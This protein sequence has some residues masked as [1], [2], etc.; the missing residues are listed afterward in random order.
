MTTIYERPSLV[1]L[2]NR[3]AS[4]LS[5]MPDILRGPLTKSLAA[6]AH[7]EHGHLD[8]IQRQGSPLTCEL[9]MLYQWASLYDVP[10]LIAMPAEG[11]VKVTGNPGTDLLIDTLARGQNGFD[12]R[13]VMGVTINNDGTASAHVRCEDAGENTN[14]LAGQT[15]T[16]IDPVA[17][18]DDALTVDENGLT[19]GANEE[20]LD[21]WRLRV[22]DEWQ[23]A[24]QVGARG[25]RDDDYRYWAKSAH[26]SVTTALVYKHK[27]GIGTVIVM[28]ICNPLADRL[29]TLSILQTVEDYIRSKAPVGGDDLY[30]VAPA[31]QPVTVQIEL[32]NASDTQSNR[33][34]IIASLSVL[35]NSK[36]A[37][38]DFILLSEIDDAISSVTRQYIRHEPNDTVTAGYGCVMTLSV[39][40]L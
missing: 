33:N 6:V 32:L 27:L 17:G 28:P 23:T 5:L 35:I 19:G 9:E 18:I 8:W 29:P 3:I 31:I 22:T 15:L 10:R 40:W 20:D 26:P 34:A 13:V 12:Y 21:V 30:I 25:G 7:G 38:S 16:L 24:V 1:T 2:Q 4:D 37:E 36:T 39:G 14:M 11:N